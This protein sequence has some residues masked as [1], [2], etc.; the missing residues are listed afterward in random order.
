MFEDIFKRFIAD[1]GYGPYYQQ[2]AW[3]FLQDQPITDVVENI[4]YLSERY[5][6]VN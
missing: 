5:P 6:K 2:Q 1:R 4:F 3:D